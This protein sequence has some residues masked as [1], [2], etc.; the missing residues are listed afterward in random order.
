MGCCSDSSAVAGEVSHEPRSGDQFHA[1][2]PPIS[3][4]NDS[5]ASPLTAIDFLKQLELGTADIKVDTSIEVLES[6]MPSPPHERENIST[7]EEEHVPAA[8]CND[9][10][11]TMAP[12][13]IS[14]HPPKEECSAPLK[15]E[16]KNF[17]LLIL[18]Q[19]I[20][21]LK[22]KRSVESILPA[23]SGKSMKAE[24]LPIPVFTSPER[25]KQ[26]QVESESL[27]LSLFLL[28]CRN[29]AEAM[30]HDKR[31]QAIKSVRVAPIDHRATPRRGM[32]SRF[33]IPGIESSN[34]RSSQALRRRSPSRENSLGQ[35]KATGSSSSS[36]SNSQSTATYGSQS[37]RYET[38]TELEPGEIGLDE[39]SRY[40]NEK[41]TEP[42]DGPLDSRLLT[43]S[44]QQR[45]FCD[46]HGIDFELFKSIRGFTRKGYVLDS[47]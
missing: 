37:S 29:E 16:Q 25:E 17:Q 47:K 22:Q 43:L 18:Q 11:T 26:N 45:S 36:L 35:M 15:E 24:L 13:P 23:S 9:F 3:P 46:Q 21:N 10:S 44:E 19:K 38:E 41:R 27:K 28:K 5:P 12:L 4:L 8:S 40:R 7:L 31:E 34:C 1:S 42:L 14:L 30:Q 6:G 33:D 32:Q 39:Q 2:L 20:E